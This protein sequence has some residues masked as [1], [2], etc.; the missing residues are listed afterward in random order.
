[1][2]E[3]RGPVPPGRVPGLAAR[4][5]ERLRGDAVVQ[6]HGPVDLGVLDV[7]ARLA[8]AARRGG[9][10]LEVRGGED[11]AGLVRLTG[12]GLV[13]Q[14]LGQAEAGEQRGVEEVVDVLDPSA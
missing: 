2:L 13:V 14:P 8:L 7:L 12:L 1:M 4:L 3:L 11:L 6:V 10:R 9:A 5:A